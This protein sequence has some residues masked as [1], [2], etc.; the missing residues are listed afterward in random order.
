ME[1]R[2]LDITVMSAEDLKDVNLISKMAVYVVVSIGNDANSTKRKTPV[3]KDGGR[4]PKWNDRFKFAVDVDAL[5]RHRDL[6]LV[7]KLKAERVLGDRDVGVVVIPIQEL[8]NNA[9][10]NGD[11]T[12]TAGS[13]RI[14]DYQVW[15]PTGKPKGTLKFSYKFGD[16]ITNQVGAKNAKPVDEPVTAYPAPAGNSAAY[17][18]PPQGIGYAPPPPSGVAPPYLHPAVYPPQPGYG[19]P[20]PPGYGGG[21]PPAQA[22]GY[23]PPLGYGGYGY[24][25][26]PPPQAQQNKK[27]MG[28]GLG[29]G[30]GAGLLGGLL[31][32]DMLSDAGDMAAYDAGYDAGFDD[33]GF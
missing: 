27:K 28:A 11:A 24:A 20:P 8:L 29:L 17:P 12:T 30:L 22:Y 2:P 26:P 4:N 10:S 16:I 32:G 7:F 5:S 13:E 3:D 31:V 21:Y 25:P 6:P 14:V 9:A 15:M 1:Y 19:Y 33:A 23:P 18:P